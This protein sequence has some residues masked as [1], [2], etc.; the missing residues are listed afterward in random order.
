MET[1]L[2]TDEREYLVDTLAIIDGEI[3]KLRGSL[4]STAAY[5]QTSLTLDKM[6]TKQQWLLILARPRPY[7]G[8]VD[9]IDTDDETEI[10][11]YIGTFPVP[12]DRVYSWTAPFARLYYMD[13]KR[14]VEYCAPK[15]KVRGQIILKRSFEIVDGALKDVKEI[16]RA[17]QLA[18][19]STLDGSKDYLVTQLQRLR[20][21][22]MREAV[23]TIQPAQYEQIAAAPKDVLQIQGV[24]GSGKSLVGLHRIAY[25]VSPFNERADRPRASQIIFF[26]PSKRFLTYVGSLLPS[27]DVREVV[28]TTVQDWLQSLLTQRVSL[29]PAD[30]LLERLL[31]RPNQ[32]S[33]EHLTNVAKTTGSLQI[34]ATLKAYIKKRRSQFIASALPLTIDVETGKSVRLNL[35]QVRQFLKN[36]PDVPLNNQR[37]AVIER[38]VNSLGRSTGLAPSNTGAAGQRWTSFVHR[39]RPEVARALSQFLA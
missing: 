32:S 25:L 31:A 28:Q 4:P 18:S 38:I 2:F 20:D 33:V 19:Q 15:G 8:R 34:A 27:L 37:A 24:A 9:F 3:E 5:E 36:L 6:S 16:Y 7:V 23:A 14:A 1:G 30:T 26:G 11:G 12:Q 29:T 21:G 17:S 13:P 10:K 39:I 22:Q 35:N